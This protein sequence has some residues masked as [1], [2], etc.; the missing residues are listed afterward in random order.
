MPKWK[1]VFCNSCEHKKIKDELLSVTKGRSDEGFTC[2]VAAF[3]HTLSL[4][5]SVWP[6]ATSHQEQPT[7]PQLWL[8][9]ST[10]ILVLHYETLVVVLIRINKVFRNDQSH[11]D[12]SVG[13]ILIHKYNWKQPKFWHE[14]IILCNFT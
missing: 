2:Q 8:N 5:A 11:C 14:L 1:S 3:K 6:A 4:K 7:H 12:L 10:F 9:T 13:F